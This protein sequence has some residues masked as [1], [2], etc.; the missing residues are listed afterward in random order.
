MVELLILLVSTGAIVLLMLS[1]RRQSRNKSE[2]D[3]GLFAFKVDPEIA[4]ETDKS[5]KKGRY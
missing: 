5:L 4:A 1:V 2:S 3:E